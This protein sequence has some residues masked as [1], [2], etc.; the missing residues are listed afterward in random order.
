MNIDE[1]CL[2]TF[3]QTEVKYNPD[4]LPVPMTN[5]AKSAKLQNCKIRSQFVSWQCYGRNFTR[6]NKFKTTYNHTSEDEARPNI[7]K[8]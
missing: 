8:H 3:H 2:R 1:L 7:E 5:D 4:V 6:H